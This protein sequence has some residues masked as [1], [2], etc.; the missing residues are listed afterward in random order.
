MMTRFLILLSTVSF[1]LAL[2]LRTRHAALARPVPVTVDAIDAQQILDSTVQIEMYEWA[3]SA[4]VEVGGRGLGTILRHDN[5]TLVVTHDHWTHLNGS[6]KEIEFRTAEGVR[7]LTVPADEFW[8]LIRYRGGGTMILSAPRGLPAA[9]PAR[10]I[11]ALPHSGDL[12]WVAR[13]SPATAYSTVELTLAQVEA[14]LADGGPARVRLRTA[15]G[16][17]V[18]PGDSGGGVWVRGVFAG[19]LWA[20]G[21][22][23]SRSWLGPLRGKPQAGATDL[24]IAATFP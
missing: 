15:D 23:I 6:L 19:N 7:L 14:L 11:A 13:H 4:G 2:A 22:E 17:V 21:V 8:P 5:T 16:T 9:A 10:A 18:T 24:I 3:S 1:A 20:G 12:A